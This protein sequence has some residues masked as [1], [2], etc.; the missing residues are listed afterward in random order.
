MSTLGTIAKPQGLDIHPQSRGGNRPVKWV[1]AR[2]YEVWPIPFVKG[3]LFR[4]AAGGVF[5]DRALRD[6]F[7]EDKYGCYSARRGLV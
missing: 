2:G 7:W 6:R 5:E 3:L 1:N 4:D